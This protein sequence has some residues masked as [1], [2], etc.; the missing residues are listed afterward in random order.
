MGN[1]EDLVINR[2]IIN[3]KQTLRLIDYVYNIWCE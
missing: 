3:N 2:A 1:Y